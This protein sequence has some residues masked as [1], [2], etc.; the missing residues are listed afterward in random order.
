DRQG[1]L[2][3]CAGRLSAE[4]LWGGVSWGHVAGMASDRLLQHAHQAPVTYLDAAAEQEQVLRFDVAMLKGHWLPAALWIRVAV[5]IK[6][7]EAAGRLLEVL[8]H[9][10]E[11]DAGPAEH[12]SLVEPV[13]QR[14]VC[15]FHAD[16][17]EA[18]ELPGAEEGYQVGVANTGHRFQ[19][20]PLDG[21]GSTGQ[22]DELE[23]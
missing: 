15:Q 3:G 9:F 22:G 12:L 18:V 13:E 20:P 16:H 7:V 21:G 5:A 2:V 10:V 19:G 23:G 4:E 17:K 8:D 6:V 14:L 11:G 1:V